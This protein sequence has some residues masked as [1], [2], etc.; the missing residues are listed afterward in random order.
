MANPF[1]A[2]DGYPHAGFGGSARAG[3][4][5]FGTKHHVLRVSWETFNSKVARTFIY[6]SALSLEWQYF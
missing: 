1:F 6:G 4:S 3:Y 5:V 2:A